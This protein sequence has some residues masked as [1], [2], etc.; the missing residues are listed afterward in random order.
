MVAPSGRSFLG[1]RHAVG[2]RI[3]RQNDQYLG[4]CHQEGKTQ[5]RRS[6]RCGDG[7]RF[8]TARPNPGQRRYG[9]NMRLWKHPQA[10]SWPISR[11]AI[12]TPFKELP[13]RRQIARLPQ[14]VADKSVA[15]GLPP[16]R[17]LFASRRPG[18]WI[19][20]RKCWTVCSDGE[21][22]AATVGDEHEIQLLDCQSGE[23][24]GMS[25]A[26]RRRWFIGIQSRCIVGSSAAA[27][28]ALAFSG[29][30]RATNLCHARRASRA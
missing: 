30:W 25:R 27:A 15:C 24:R 22:L 12:P 17:Y 21:L 2:E 18:R 11:K 13:S 10:A 1:G 29:T 9:Q 6:R 16:Y 20:R 26:S 4:R 8:L 28:I 3:G 7:D 19:S 14:R 5:P 23:N